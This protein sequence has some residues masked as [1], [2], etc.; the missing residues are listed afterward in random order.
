MC[1]LNCL[2]CS[3]VSTCYFSMLHVCFSEKCYETIHLRYYVAGET[4]GRIHLRNV[5]QCTC[6][7]GE[8]KCERVRY[9]S[10]IRRLCWP[11]QKESSVRIV[12]SVNFMILMQPAAKVSLLL[13]RCV[14]LI[15]PR[16]LQPRHG[17]KDRLYDSLWLRNGVAGHT[18]WVWEV[19]SPQR[20]TFV[21]IHHFL[22]QRT[23]RQEG[24]FMLPEPKQGCFFVMVVGVYSIRHGKKWHF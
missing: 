24:G 17:W 13:P 14:S 1:C 18:P 7:A 19:F 15:R 11:E 5:E 8:I 23:W 20:G 9:T 21:G 3:H 6:A 2:L 10:K 22:A 16:G 4:W 12:V